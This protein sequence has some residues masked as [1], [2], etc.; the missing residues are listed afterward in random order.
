MMNLTHAIQGTPVLTRADTVARAEAENWPQPAQDLLC[1]S[2]AQQRHQSR[3]ARCYRVALA[4]AGEIDPLGQRNGEIAALLCL[5]G[6]QGVGGPMNLG[7]EEPG[8][9]RQSAR[10]WPWSECCGKG[11]AN[12]SDGPAWCQALYCAQTRVS[13][14]I[15]GDYYVPS[16]YVAAFAAVR[17]WAG[18]DTERLT[19][20]AQVQDHLRAHAGRRILND[21]DPWRALWAEVYS[22]CDAPFGATA[23]MS[24]Q[25]AQDLRVRIQGIEEAEI[26]AR[27][28]IAPPSEGDGEVMDDEGETILVWRPEE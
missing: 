25:D 22:A 9:T 11:R 27:L 26:A 20:A 6:W 1:R 23:P 3:V 28:V 14:D 18:E 13:H 4:V 5:A 17:E 8:G 12:A 15:V 2:A 24:V 10:I 21:W 16:G 19:W 7:A